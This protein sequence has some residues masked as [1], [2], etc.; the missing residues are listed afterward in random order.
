MPS[1][2]SIGAGMTLPVATVLALANFLAGSLIWTAA[3]PSMNAADMTSAPQA[4][5]N[6]AAYITNNITGAILGSIA[7]AFIDG[8]LENSAKKR[9]KYC[10]RYFIDSRT[11]VQKTA[12]VVIILMCSIMSTTSRLMTMAACIT[13]AAL[14]TAVLNQL[15]EMVTYNS[16]KTATKALALSCHDV[17]AAFPELIVLMRMMLF[18]NN[19]KTITLG[20]ASA[21]LINAGGITAFTE[22]AGTGARPAI[23]LPA[24]L[25]AN[26]GASFQI[27]AFLAHGAGTQLDISPEARNLSK[28]FVINLWADVIVKKS[29]RTPTVFDDSWFWRT[30]GGDKYRLPAIAT[31]PAPPAGATLAELST[32]ATAVLTLIQGD[33]QVTVQPYGNMPNA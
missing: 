14:R 29:D 15:R 27:P 28:L 32:Y 24:N 4:V 8:G 3:F 31:V 6:Q 1:D 2:R 9:V 22:V 21:A 18:G 16:E 5:V 10:S 20:T 25:A 17:K 7:G 33:A 30:S 26:A 23:T 12:S 11:T 19:M 13:D